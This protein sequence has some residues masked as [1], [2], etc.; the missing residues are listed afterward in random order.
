MGRIITI[1]REFGSG[2]KELGRLL[3]K[4]L[5]IAYYD[6]EIVTAIAKKT[7]LAE[8][9]VK[10]IVEK[11]PSLFFPVTVGQTLYA[12]PYEVLQ[13]NSAVQIEQA[14]I[15]K[16]MAAKSD[17]VIVGRCAD[18]IL[19]DLKPFRIFVY[20]D[21]E[22]RM[23]RCKERGFKEE[24]LTEKKIK[25]LVTRVDK[26]RASYYNFYTGQK[27]GNRLN[28]DICINTT[29]VDMEKIATFLAKMLT[30]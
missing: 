30:E 21:L 8:D 11:K 25:K 3:A 10:Q 24:G 17:C 7:D 4:K 1:G 16:E 20:A 22:A 23:A 15:I 28:Y 19:R 5:N 14:N 26:H 27:W 12:A 29:G 2:G 9:Y 6:N 18:Y 13:N